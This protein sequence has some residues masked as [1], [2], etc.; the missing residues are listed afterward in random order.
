M[1]CPTL[2]RVFDGSRNLYWIGEYPLYVK[3]THDG[4]K[5]NCAPSKLDVKKWLQQKRIIGQRFVTRS[6][7]LQVLLFC[8]QEP[9]APEPEQM[10]KAYRTKDGRYRTAAGLYLKGSGQSWDVYD[11]QDQHLGNTR[12][13]L[14]R[15]L[16][17]AD[18]L[19]NGI[20]A[21]EDDWPAHLSFDRHQRG[22]H[23][24]TDRP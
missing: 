24:G 19:F 2:H 4:W 20:Q 15:A 14:W 5:I 21:A 6:E 7:A 22:I 11:Q 18:S 10:P 16:W 9:G 12:G 8:L 23:D 3:K 13:S 1:I 17:V